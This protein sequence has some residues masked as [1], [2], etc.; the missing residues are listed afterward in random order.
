MAEATM[1]EEKKRAKRKKQRE[2]HEK[3]K[4]AKPGEGL[5]LGRAV[6]GK[7]K[8]VEWKYN[9]NGGGARAEHQA[10]RRKNCLLGNFCC[11]HYS[12]S[13]FIV[14]LAR[15][16]LLVWRGGFVGSKLFLQ[17]GVRGWAEKAK[18]F[19]V[20]VV[21]LTLLSF[22]TFSTG[23]KMGGWG[24]SNFV[25]TIGELFRAWCCCDGIGFALSHSLLAR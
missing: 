15:S 12:I 11:S 22:I 19:H 23:S 17:S 25:F 13:L 10:R 14:A 3:K 21:L 9:T 8:L 16:S 24:R 5:G 7:G 4:A 18:R 2:G 6:W 1:S 20:V